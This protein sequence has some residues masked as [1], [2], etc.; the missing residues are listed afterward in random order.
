MRPRDLH[1]LI[2]QALGAHAVLGR[3]GFLPEEIFMG[4]QG[5]LACGGPHLYVELRAQDRV[6]RYDVGHVH[7]DLEEFQ[8]KVLEG[9]KIWNESPQYERDYVFKHCGAR[10]DAVVLLD[11]LVNKGIMPPQRTI[12]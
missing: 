5:N 8:Q 2:F 12:H 10:R 6:F 9:Y 11:A 1:P 7:G 3:M 4:I